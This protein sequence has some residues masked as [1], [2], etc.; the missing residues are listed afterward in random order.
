MKKLKKYLIIT[1][2]FVVVFV[3]ISPNFTQLCAIFE[4]QVYPQYYAFLLQISK[5]APATSVICVAL[6]MLLILAKHSLMPDV[7]FFKKLYSIKIELFLILLL[8]SS[9]WL[10]NPVLKT[11]KLSNVATADR[12][13]GLNVNVSSEKG[14]EQ[15]SQKAKSENADIIFVTSNSNNEYFLKEKLESSGYSHLIKSKDS[16]IHIYS[17]YELFPVEGANQNQ[18]T[19]VVEKDNKSYLLIGLNNAQANPLEAR[20]EIETVL[21]QTISKTYPAIL[22]GYLNLA[23][24]DPGF[25]TIQN[26]YDMLKISYPLVSGNPWLKGFF[27]DS[28]APILGSDNLKFVSHE[29]AN[30][31]GQRYRGELF[32]LDTN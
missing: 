9:Y 10:A 27:G 12:L 32:I 4:S 28:S 21:G 13:T 23:P 30:I 16:K 7:G 14:A 6:V 1:L 25:N 17:K 15:L 20:K 3:G 18:A 19:A 26:K 24:T 2:L 22:G 5:Y 29:V 11:Q 31:S 8:S